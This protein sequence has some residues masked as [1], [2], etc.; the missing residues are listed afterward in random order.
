MSFAAP[1]S[2][3]GFWYNGDLYVEVGGLNRHKRAPV[4][5]ITAILRPD[6]KK[7]KAVTAQPSK[8]PV[9]HWYEAQLLHYGL[10]PS[11]DK[12]RAK[13]RLLEAVNNSSLVVPAAI[14]RLEESLRKEFNAVEKKAK[15]QYKLQ[16]GGEPKDATN[17]RKRKQPD[18]APN[19]NVTVNINGMGTMP[20]AGMPSP[21]ATYAPDPIEQ[22]LHSP[23]KKA[24][25][26]PKTDRKIKAATTKA[27]PPQ[28]ASNKKALAAKDPATKKP[29]ATAKAV[30]SKQ[31]KN[32][33]Q[34]EPIV[35]REPTVKKQPAVKKEPPMKKEPAVK[36]ESI[37]K[38]VSTV[39]KEPVMKETPTGKQW[40]VKAEGSHHYP[41]APNIVSLG[42]ING[43]YDIECP[44]MRE[45]FGD[46][47]DP[48]SLSLIL[49]LD[50]PRI[51]GAYDFGQ[52]SGILLLENRP[53]SASDE[54]L[55]IKWRGRENG[56][57]EMDF[58]DHC[59]G[60]IAFQGNGQITGM[61]NLFGDCE[62]FG[63]RQPGPGTAIRP[64]ASMGQ[65]W[66][67]YNDS[68]YNDEA[69]NRW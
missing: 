21:F 23:S 63:K 66:D 35:K 9:G 50:G 22:Q 25:A 57:G 44:T 48:D 14:S 33:A 38:K 64:A 2:K 6:L 36:K 41:S 18:S 24:K 47:F 28:T 45:Q 31:E 3:D 51:W 17:P 4:A 65:E 29:S 40:A 15:A 8:D 67:G 60:E 69:S 68:V 58:G 49:T 54:A 13:M 20:F 42:L 34:K 39:K 27:K 46:N 16:S 19:V 59:Y 56:E 43:Y 61:L 10:P 12:A 30:I 5:E 53:Y 52:F 1:V 55:P 62:F 11:K 7:S 37:A 26:S 32:G